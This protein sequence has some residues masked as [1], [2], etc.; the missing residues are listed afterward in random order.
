MLEGGF[1]ATTIGSLPHKDAR[2]AM[3]ILLEYTP[4]IPAWPQLPKR[5]PKEQMIPQFALGLP[6]IERR[7]GR[8]FINTERPSF[9]DELLQFYEA[10]LAAS[11][12]GDSEA[13]ERFGLP[14]QRAAGFHAL[15]DV[16]PS[17]GVEPVAV[18]GQLTGPFTL[19]T[20]VTDQNGR[21]AYYDHRLRDAIVKY[22]SMNARW[23]ARKLK[24]LSPQ[25][26]LFLDE[27][28]LSAYGSS[29]FLG[30]SERDILADL[31]E[32]VSA[33]HDE[34]G[35]AGVHCCGNTDW[36]L[37][38]KSGVDILSF[39]AYEF[40][41]RLVLYSADLGA[42]LERGGLV[43]WGIVP[44]LDPEAL[45]K[46]TVGSLLDR[47]KAQFRTLEGAGV[48]PDLLRRRALITPSCGASSLTEELAERA[49][50]LT[51]DLSQAAREGI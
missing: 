11:E 40:F 41:D 17:S 43:A 25:V 38:L 32:V 4:E 7:D 29:A 9:D 14:E 44:S 46:E 35:L 36:S 15:L 50:K 3:G 18:K 31:V 13:L 10:Y 27:P 19:G 28:A 16:L 21:Y 30:V 45:E 39:D 34:G 24:R 33:I 23:Q 1:L 12:G 22:L 37:L 8:I 47:L 26:L 48:P 20:G 6:E 5:S 51:A 42:F 2:R 49:L